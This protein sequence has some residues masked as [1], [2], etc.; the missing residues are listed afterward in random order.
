MKNEDGEKWKKLKVPVKALVLLKLSANKNDPIK[1]GKISKGKPVKPNPAFKKDAWKKEAAKTNNI[2]SSN[3]GKKN[4][5]VKTSSLRTG[6][7]SRNIP[8]KGILKSEAEER[9]RKKSVTINPRE[10]KSVTYGRSKRSKTKINSKRWVLRRGRVS[11]QNK[12][13]L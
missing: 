10:K 7:G 12:N 9:T 6:P 2:I 1:K 8:K 4:V 11:F 3:S 13:Q 5:D